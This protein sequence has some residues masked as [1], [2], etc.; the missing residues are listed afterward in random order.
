MHQIAALKFF[1][2]SFTSDL[3]NHKLK[4]KY[5]PVIISKRHPLEHPQL[6]NCRPNLRVCCMFCSSPGSSVALMVVDAWMGKCWF[7]DAKV[8]SGVEGLMQSTDSSFSCMFAVCATH[9]EGVVNCL[10]ESGGVGNIVEGVLPE[11][12]G[13]GGE[14]SISPCSDPECTGVGMPP[15]SDRTERTSDG[16]HTTSVVGEASDSLTAGE[17]LLS[18]DSASC[19]NKCNMF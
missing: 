9:V 10:S 12:W 13:M 16:G 4:W 15:H 18:S 1:N 19:E 11:Y 6:M 7:S 14:A 17:M 8:F 3:N 2:L 5:F